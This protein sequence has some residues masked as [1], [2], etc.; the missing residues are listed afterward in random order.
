M[1]QKPI[2]KSKK[3]YGIR[4]GDALNWCIYSRHTILE[5]KRK[6]EVIEENI[7]FYHSFETCCLG[8]FYFSVGKAMVNKELDE[9]V[10]LK[11]I[12]KAEK[13]IIK[14]IKKVKA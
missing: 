5:G 14:E 12:D 4:K 13:D 10:M 7:K 11:A 1:K 8:F 2:K 6:G 3:K 9:Y